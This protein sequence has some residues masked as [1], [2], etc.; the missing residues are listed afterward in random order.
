MGIWCDDAVRGFLGA[1]VGILYFNWYGL[2]LKNRGRSDPYV[3]SGE[4]QEGKGDV[5]EEEV[6]DMDG[7]VEFGKAKRE[8][9]EG[10]EGKE[11]RGW[12]EVGRINGGG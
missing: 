2:K 6:V 12:R 11:G 7:L 4:V 8:L 3:G 9:L 1:W 10:K 5:V